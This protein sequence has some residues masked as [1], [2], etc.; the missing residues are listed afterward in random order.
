[1]RTG[2]APV[3]SGARVLLTAR[4]RGDDLAAALEERGAVVLRAPTITPVAESTRRLVRRTDA[5]LREDVD[6]VVVTT[7]TG[8]E[9]WLAT[10][11]SAGADDSVLG[12]LRRARVVAR[13]PKVRAALEA[14]GVEPDWLGEAETSAEIIEFLLAEGVSGASVVLVHAGGRDEAGE[15]A[16]RRAGAR[17]TSVRAYRWVSLDDRPEVAASVEEVGQGRFDAVLFTSA[18]GARAWLRAVRRAELLDVVRDRTDSRQLLLGAVGPVT[19]EPLAFAGLLARVPTTSRL[20]DLVRLVIEELGDDRHALLTGHGLL[21]LRAGTI[22]L[23]HRAVALPP[24]GLALLR[25][26]ASTPGDVVSREEL[27]RVLPGAST[28]PHTAEVAVARLREALR[29][30]TGNDT[31]DGGLVKTVVRRGYVLAAR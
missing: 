4:R 11:S 23:D 14:V 25:R 2:N 21:R 30:A 7:A 31:G 6:V 17:V 13:G 24:S 1:M 3:L 29:V 16:L 9:R 26:L 10:A 22:T 27:L 5:V 15:G 8:L 12:L 20:A 28:D 18:P 19:A